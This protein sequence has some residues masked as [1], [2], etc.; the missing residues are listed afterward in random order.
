MQ[1]TD[2]PANKLINPGNHEATKPPLV[3]VLG[4]TAVGKTEISIQLAERLKGEIV[5]VDSRLL[6]R[7][8][9]IGTAKPS[10]QELSRVPHHLIDVSQPDQVWSLAVFKAAASLAIAEIHTRKRLPFL[11]GGTGQYIRAIVEQWEIPSAQPNPRLRRIL[12]KW[13]E[14]ESQHRLHQRLAI[15]DPEAAERIDPRNLRRTVRALEVILTTGRQFSDQRR[16]FPGQYRLFFVGLTRP[17]PEL[18]ARVD[19]RIDHM[20]ET[21]LV[22]EVRTLLAQGYASDLPAFSAIGYREIISY[23]KGELSLEDAAAQ[24]KRRTRIF[25]RRQANW[26][27]RDAEN[28]RWYQVRPF[29]EDEIETDIRKWLAA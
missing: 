2:E 14:R 24:M 26:F 12:E 6:Y 13:A 10:H 17:R 5:S 1:S 25:V 18:C 9:D 3:V 21:G 20:L 16:Q 27:K 19:A 4:P 23:L 8:M 11:V 15:L 22:E 28:I 7:G 29:V